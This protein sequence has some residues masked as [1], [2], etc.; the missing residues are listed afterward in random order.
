MHFHGARKNAARNVLV[1][2]ATGR[3]CA[4]LSRLSGICTHNYNALAASDVTFVQLG[5]CWWTVHQHIPS[6]TKVTSS[7]PLAYTHAY[8]IRQQYK[9]PT[10][11]HPYFAAQP[12]TSPTSWYCNTGFHMYV[13]IP[14]R[15][16]IAFIFNYTSIGHP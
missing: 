10:K 14:T 4:L 11:A 7:I 16:V 8:V 13:H 15:L 3:Q 12:S 1:N 9:V 5:M 6:C 2:T